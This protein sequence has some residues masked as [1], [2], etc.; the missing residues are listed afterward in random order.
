LHESQDD[1]VEAHYAS[2]ERPHACMDGWVFLGRVVESERPRWRGRR[3][4]ARAL[5]PLRGWPIA[6]PHSLCRCHQRGHRRVEDSRRLDDNACIVGRVVRPALVTQ[7]GLRFAPSLRC[8]GASVVRTYLSPV[9][10]A[11]H[12][13]LYLQHLRVRHIGFSH[14]VGAFS[15]LGSGPSLCSVPMPQG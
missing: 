6:P 8:A 15:L 4:R 2:L 13:N 5:P 9:G 1:S 11:H 14:R 7:R 10:R 3:V 12:A